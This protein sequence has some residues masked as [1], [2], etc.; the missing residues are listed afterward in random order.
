MTYNLVTVESLTTD[1]VMAALA[2]CLQVPVQ[3]VDVAD[4]AGDQ[5]QRD[6]DALVLCDTV[7][8]RGD[9]S[10]SLDIYI[11]EACNRGR[12][13]AAWPQPSPG[14]PGPWCCFRPR[15]RRPVPTGWSRKKD[16][17]RGHALYK[18]ARQRR[19]SRRPASAGGVVVHARGPCERT[20]V[21]TAARRIR[22]GLRTCCPGTPSRGPGCGPCGGIGRPCP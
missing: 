4:E 17:S 10:T 14:Q 18:A 22:T 11:Q 8:L 1:T 12:A 3:G 2:Q 5:D 7:R 20:G 9:V 21:L 19:G 15:K 13:S 6:W 16:S